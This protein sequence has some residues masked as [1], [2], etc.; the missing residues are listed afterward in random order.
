MVLMNIVGVKEAAVIGVPDK[1]LGQAVKA[2]LV[3]ESG[4]QV[5]ENDVQ[6]ECLKY[7]ENFMVPKFV[8][9]VPELPKTTTGKVK[10]TDLL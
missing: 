8:S 3:L 5:S 6:R 7:L 1:L 4:A 9:I 10:K 2:F